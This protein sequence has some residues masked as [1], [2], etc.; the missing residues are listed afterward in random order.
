MM[1]TE[2]SFCEISGNAENGNR[3]DVFSNVM[4][5]RFESKNDVS[6]HP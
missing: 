1:K 6:F 5:G 3:N 4:K 2:T